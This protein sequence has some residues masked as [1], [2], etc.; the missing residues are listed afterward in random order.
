MINKLRLLRNKST[1]VNEIIN[2]YP[3]TIGEIEDIGEEDYRMYLNCLLIDK[4]SLNSEGLSREEKK[5][6][7]KITPLDTLL[8]YCHQDLE[9]RRITE[10]SFL[11]FTKEEVEY[12][13]NDEHPIGCFYFY[14]EG[15]KILLDNNLFNEFRTILM[16]QNYLQDQQSSSGFKPANN[17]A[18]EL[19]ERMNKIKEKLNK[20]NK[21]ESLPLSEIVSI[22]S[23]YSNDVNILTVWDLT[24]FQLYELYA[25]LLLWD[26][27]HN[28]Y[29]HLP[30][31]EKED[32]EKI[33]KNHWAK[34]L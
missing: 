21:E 15:N 9:F 34:K 20:Q 17:K 18:T 19:M 14:V 1:T 28:D 6:F 30:H 4:N 24:I 13:I 12:S 31:M 10:E 5:E 32:Q 2:V 29:I 7:N 23:A 25:R 33:S 3:L 27:Y 11:I 26:S 22:V 16:K 8:L